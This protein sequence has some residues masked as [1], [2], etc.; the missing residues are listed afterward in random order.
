M[1]CFVLLEKA[2]HAQIVSGADYYTNFDN[3][4]AFN[5]EQCH[6]HLDLS[7]NSIDK[8]TGKIIVQAA[9]AAF[10]AR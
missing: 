10:P 1:L 9:G 8:A 6:A 4:N 7:K 5:E 3:F 2:T